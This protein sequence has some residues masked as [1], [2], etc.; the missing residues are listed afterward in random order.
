MADDTIAFGPGKAELLQA[1]AHS[2]SISGGA[3]EMEMSYRRAWLLVEQMNR[4]FHGPLVLTSTGGSKGGGA[5]VTDLAQ[6][7]LQRY[8]AMQLKADAAI[9]DDM[10]Y[11]QGLMRN[12]NGRQQ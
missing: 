7:I 8:R 10:Q 2:G 9:Q 1:I 6:D 5:Q 3:R 11:L 12:R 4:C